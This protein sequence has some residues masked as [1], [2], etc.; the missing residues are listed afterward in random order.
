MVWSC[1]HFRN[2]LLG[3]TFEVLTDHKTIISAFQSNRGKQSYQSRLTRWAVII[4]PFDF[5]VTHNAGTKLG[6]VDYLSGHPTFEA[7]QPSSFD[8]QF[9][10][11]SIQSF[12]SACTTVD[13]LYNKE[14]NDAPIP[15][16]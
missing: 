13:N 8:E 14:C 2:H 4:L 12:F 11:K 16:Q 6:I 9:V 1:E 7:P 10:V 15:N 5:K 3:N